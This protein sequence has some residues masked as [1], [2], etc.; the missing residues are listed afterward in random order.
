MTLLQACGI[1]SMLL[2]FLIV[3]FEVML[4]DS[5]K[6]SSNAS[7]MT[8]IE[9]IQLCRQVEGDTIELEVGLRSVSFINYSCGEED[10]VWSSEANWEIPLFNYGVAIGCSL[11]LCSLSVVYAS[12]YVTIFLL[13]PIF[14]CKLWLFEKKK[15]VTLMCDGFLWCSKWDVNEFVTLV[16]GKLCKGM[17]TVDS[18]WIRC[19]LYLRMLESVS[20]VGWG[21]NDVEVILS[22]VAAVSSA[23]GLTTVLLFEVNKKSLETKKMCFHY[24]YAGRQ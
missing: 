13:V 11:L 7:V 24:V 1:F 15:V 3:P 5:T 14:G 2:T 19:I 9:T 8:P 20:A 23:I 21:T 17:L 6:L 4:V 18:R 22:S 10:G 16:F 12:L